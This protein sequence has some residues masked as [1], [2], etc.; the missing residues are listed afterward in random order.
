MNSAL[1]KVLHRIAGRS[2]LAHVL[3]A[4]RG[5]GA[6]RVAVVIGPGREDVA[7]EARAACPDAAIFVQSERLGTA[8][9]VLA[10][11]AALEVPSDDV[12]VAYADTP[13]VSPDTFAT[14][15]T[16]LGGGA[17]VA[18]LGFEARDPAGYGRLL[19][20]GDRLTA[21]RE[22]RDASA[23][24]RAIT[25]SNAG[26][27]AFRG[28]AALGLLRAIGNA[29]SKRE[30]YLP[31]AVAVAVAA[32]EHAAVVIAPEDEV[33][34]VNDRAQLAAAE[35]VIQ[36]RLRRR[37]MAGGVTMVDPASVFLSADTRLGRDVVLE[38]NVWFGPGVSV[39]DNVSIRA[40]SHLEG[41][42]VA[43]GAIVGPFARLRPGASL[44][45]G[46]HVGNFVEVKNA[47]LAAGVKANHLTYLGDA[48]VGAG[49]N[50]GAG[51]ITC[52]YDGVAKHRTEIGAGAFIGTNTLLVAPVS[53]GDRAYTATGS[54]ITENVPADALALGR[55]RQVNK[56]GWAATRRAAAAKS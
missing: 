9:A 35:A 13:L 11:A 43:A 32:G 41:A 18:V 40:F 1:P 27:M 33:Q 34:G 52:N 53:V 26:L 29:N 39:G 12:V 3:D 7:V 31:D 36:D 8:H 48:T 4:V 5:A 14:L 24:E 54:V 10:A 30:Y 45:E 56:E 19:M 38:P 50:V 15:R 25:L 23:A 55:A 42:T 28:D 46:A 21:I 6:D 17:A 37:A 51:T 20:E 22:E 49:T 44:G 47:T 16:P 2:M